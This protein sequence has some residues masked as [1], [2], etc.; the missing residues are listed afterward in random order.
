VSNGRIVLKPCALKV[1]VALLFTYKNTPKRK[2]D[3]EEDAT[4][5][6]RQ[7][8]PD[9]NP[10]E[11]S[12]EERTGY[13]R[14]QISRAVRELREMGV[15]ETLPNT[16][17]AKRRK[18]GKLGAQGYV[19]L[20][21]NSDDRLA[22]QGHTSVTVGNR[23]SYF[24]VPAAVVTETTKRWSLAQMTASEAVLYV[25]TLWMA[26]RE[27]TNEFAT[28]QAELRRLSGLSPVT[29]NAALNT[30]EEVGLL[31]VRKT[32][33]NNAIVFH[34]QLC[35]PYT[36]M[37]LLQQDGVVENDPQNYFTKDAKGRDRRLDINIHM[38]DA[39]AVERLIRDG[40][41]YKG[42]IIEQGNG[43]LK[44]CCPF[45]DDNTPSCSVS[46]TKQGCFRCFGC[47]KRG[48]LFDLVRGIATKQIGAET[49]ANDEDRQLT[50]RQPDSDAEAIYSYRDSKGE[51]LKQVL[52]Y[53]KD[54]NGKK[55][56][57]QRQPVPGGWK[58]SVN[59]LP[60]M[61]LNEEKQLEFCDT[62]A[63]TEGEKDACTVTNLHLRGQYGDVL[64]TTSGGATSW[65][66]SLAK[67]L[68]GDW[69]RVVVMPDA[70]EAGKRW[71]TQVT[72]SLD[73]EGINYRVVSFDGTGCKDVTDYLEENSV[74][75]LVRRIGT[76]WIRMPDGTWL[77]DPESDTPAEPSGEDCEIVW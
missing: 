37:P 41:G 59:D 11:R 15:L 61:L 32:E 49:T 51:L 23:I 77:T 20:R 26:N 74:E 34:V 9:K 4:V 38:N 65:D 69:R 48:S 42:P 47:G 75:D 24:T 71:E 62:V 6:V 67:R 72:E 55:V 28:T 31:E 44:L 56:F 3:A 39:A 58:W 33:E 2:R 57:R 35:D 68:T 43:N 36:G 22:N 19:F 8:R 63:V 18:L 29:F 25:A 1:L 21:P 54:E 5:Y 7:S 12:L 14:R 70:D 64:G 76:D 40:I 53:G 16:T 13:E 66:A 50:I 52:Y 30:L 46:P 45:H 17:T 60:P 73:A 27:R 10:K